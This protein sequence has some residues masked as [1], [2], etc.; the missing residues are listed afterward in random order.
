[1]ARQC[2]VECST[3]LLLYCVTR[4]SIVVG[5]SRYNMSDSVTPGT[6]LAV[7]LDRKPRLWSATVLNWT[8]PWKKLVC[9]SK[10]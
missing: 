7:E 5:P 9:G 1:M 2:V 6:A 3:G 8:R 4:I 10:I